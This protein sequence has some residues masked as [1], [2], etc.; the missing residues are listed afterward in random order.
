M[1]SKT[2]LKPVISPNA[3]ALPR[4]LQSM[5]T[6]IELLLVWAPNTELT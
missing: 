1:V 3:G 5:S 4:M 6:P 2:R